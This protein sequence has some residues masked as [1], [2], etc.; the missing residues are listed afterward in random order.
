MRTFDREGFEN[1]LC[2]PLPPRGASRPQYGSPNGSPRRAA[3]QPLPVCRWCSKLGRPNAA[4]D[5]AGW[6]L[7]MRSKCS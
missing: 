3:R 7:N 1:G 4:V 6:T 2:R 5:D